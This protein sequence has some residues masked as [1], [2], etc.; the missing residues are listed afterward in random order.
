MSCKCKPGVI[1]LCKGRSCLLVVLS[2]SCFVVIC[3]HTKELFVPILSVVSFPNFLQIER[4]TWDFTSKT[5]T[6]SHLF[7]PTVLSLKTKKKQMKHDFICGLSKALKEK[8]KLD[9]K[10]YCFVLE[11]CIMDF[12]FIYFKS[13]F[14]YASNCNGKTFYQYNAIHNMSIYSFFHIIT[15][16]S[17]EYSTTVQTNFYKQSFGPLLYKLLC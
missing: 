6:L 7:A 14:K 2:L 11:I 9:F 3:S 15:Y 13:T 1:L 8:I 12:K 17:N 10:D 4:K 16:L 5:K